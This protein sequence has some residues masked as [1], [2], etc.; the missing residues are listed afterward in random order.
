MLETTEKDYFEIIMV[1]NPI[2]ILFMAVSAFFIFIFTPFAYGV[3]WF[4]KNCASNRRTII[5]LFVASLALVFV[6]FS[7]MIQLPE[8]I[9]Y[10]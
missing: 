10:D 6:E 1:N 9:R 8:L 4:I 2:K 5:N 3:H 7:L